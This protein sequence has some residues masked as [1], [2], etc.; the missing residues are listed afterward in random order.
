MDADR[1]PDPADLDLARLEELV[2]L[3]PADPEFGADLG[4]FE[5]KRQTLESR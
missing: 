2:R 5:E 1:A 4:R 3:G